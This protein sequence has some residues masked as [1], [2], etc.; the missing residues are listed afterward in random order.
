MSYPLNVSVQYTDDEQYRTCI[1][2][3]FGPNLEN[4]NSLIQYIY[5]ITKTNARLLHLYE[6]TAHQLLSMDAQMGLVVLFSY[7]YL[8]SFHSILS[9]Y[10]LHNTIDS[11]LDELMARINDK[12]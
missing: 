5:D 9:H 7:D 4:F 10:L 2:E 6:I 1:E 12:K 8:G 3:I 11:S